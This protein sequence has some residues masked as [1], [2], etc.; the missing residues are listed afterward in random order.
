VK[1]EGRNSEGRCEEYFAVLVDHGSI[2]VV[3]SVMSKLKIKVNRNYTSDS[4]SSDS[5][6]QPDYTAASNFYGKKMLKCSSE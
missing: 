5:I 6:V 3:P 4:H 1:N 2:F